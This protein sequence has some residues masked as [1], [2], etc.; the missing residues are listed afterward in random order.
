MDVPRGGES[1]FTVPS[2]RSEPVTGPR[3]PSGGEP[4]MDGTMIERV[5]VRRCRDEEGSSGTAPAGNRTLP[6]HDGGRL[7]PHASPQ[8]VG[9]NTMTSPKARKKTTAPT[10]DRRKRNTPPSSVGRDP[11][12][13]Q[14][15]KHK[16]ISSRVAGWPWRPCWIP[17]MTGSKS[18][19]TAFCRWVWLAVV[20][21]CSLAVYRGN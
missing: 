11:M 3:I 2:M 7:L 17:A 5:C 1:G 6:D 20:S 18:S 13:L 9:G 16:P 12:L 14:G 15:Q 19:P 8:A 21:S 10:S 4:L